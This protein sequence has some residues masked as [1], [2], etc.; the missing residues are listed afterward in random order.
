LNI[1]QF[2]SGFQWLCY[3]LQLPSV[4]TARLNTPLVCIHD[5]H[6]TGTVL[7]RSADYFDPEELVRVFPSSD[8]WEFMA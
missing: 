8:H 2:R 6:Y 3:I 7:V 5:S 1:Q 4:Q